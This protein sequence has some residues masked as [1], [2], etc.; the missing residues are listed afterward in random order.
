MK[1]LTKLTPGDIKTMSETEFTV[2]LLV[3]GPVRPPRRENGKAERYLHDDD[4]NRIWKFF[5]GSNYG[6]RHAIAISERLGFAIRQ[7]EI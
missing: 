1:L 3:V 5:G 6:H 4:F 7:E 2:L